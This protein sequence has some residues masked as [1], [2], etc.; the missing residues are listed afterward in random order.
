MVV[1][2]RD[3]PKYQN[4]C[5]LLI[6]NLVQLSERDLKPAISGFQVRRPNHAATLPP[7]LMF[8][9]LELTALALE[10]YECTNLPGFSGEGKCDD[11]KVK[12]ITCES[13]MDRCMTI[14]GTVTIPNAGSF[15]FQLKNC[16]S[17]IVCRPDSPFN[18][19]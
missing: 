14:E 4:L 19:K 9:L 1:L 13:F 6:C 8:Y 3:F 18:S 5:Q 10:C 15:D 16:S 7:L 17:S 11:E 2:S 12:S